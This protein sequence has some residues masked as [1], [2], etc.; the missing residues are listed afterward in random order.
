ML[1]CVAPGFDGPAVLCCDRQAY[2]PMVLDV[3]V[4]KV[5]TLEN[6]QMEAIR[7]LWNDG[8]LQVC[9]ERRREYQLSDSAK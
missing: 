1:C 6:G 7:A 4:D 8:G 5:Q 3:E 2:V 9:Y